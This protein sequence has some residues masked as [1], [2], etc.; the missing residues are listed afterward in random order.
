VIEPRKEVAEADAFRKAEGN[1][2]PRETEGRLGRGQRAGHVSKGI[3][4]T[5]EIS[6]TPRR[7]GT[8]ERRKRSEAEVG[9]KSE[10]SIVARTEGNHAGGTLSSEAS[11]GARNRLEER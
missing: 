1:I 6:S 11:A 3:L 4:E 8:A 7:G 5:W 10:C 9:E 2:G